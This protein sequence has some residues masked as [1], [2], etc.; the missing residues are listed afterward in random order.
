MKLLI[1]VLSLFGCNDKVKDQNNI[2]ITNKIFIELLQDFQKSHC[3]PANTKIASVSIWINQNDTTIGLYADKI[4]KKEYYIGYLNI[5]E[6]EIYFYSNEKGSLKGLYNIVSDPSVL[7]DSSW[8]YKE[9]YTQF[10]HYH[11]GRF[12]LEK[13]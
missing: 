7:I 5:D 1:L 12:I 6:N 11:N 3:K 8:D 13:P 9:T 4:L 10:Y 2:E